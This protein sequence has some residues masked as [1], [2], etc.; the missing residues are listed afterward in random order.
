MIR[1][2]GPQKFDFLKLSYY[3]SIQWQPCRELKGLYKTALSLNFGTRV[4]KI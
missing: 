4:Q 2:G 1:G 3:D